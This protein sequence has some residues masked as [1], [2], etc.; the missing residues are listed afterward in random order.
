MPE[1]HTSFLQSMGTPVRPMPRETDIRSFPYSDSAIQE[2][3]KV[4]RSTITYSYLSEHLRVL[5]ANLYSA[6]PNVHIKPSMLS[7]T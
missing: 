4:S 6:K 7:V 5:L 1:L 2:Y 3:T